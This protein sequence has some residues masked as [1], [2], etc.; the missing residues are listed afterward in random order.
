M[1]SRAGGSRR[2]RVLMVCIYIDK[3]ASLAPG[4][5]S[6]ATIPKVTKA[7]N[8]YVHASTRFSLQAMPNSYLLVKHTVFKYSRTV[9]IQAIAFQL[10]C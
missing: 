7:H 1:F 4:W 5:W 8:A 6:L 3:Y 10:V 9:H 2:C